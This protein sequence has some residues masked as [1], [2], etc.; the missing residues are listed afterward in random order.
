METK[1]VH[2]LR[3]DDYAIKLC[4]FFRMKM[5]QKDLLV[6]LELMIILKWKL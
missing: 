4:T 2:T 3:L 6:L 1:T 5:T